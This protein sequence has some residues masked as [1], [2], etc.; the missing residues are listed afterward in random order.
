MNE[1]IERHHQDLRPEHSGQGKTRVPV[2]G[3]DALVKAVLL[4]CEARGDR[5]NATDL[6]QSEHAH[7]HFIVRHFENEEYVEPERFRR[8]GQV[9]VP[10]D[11][12]AKHL[13][14]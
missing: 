9:R 1:R 7:G 4:E 10:A 12:P 5:R 13:S 2:L 14:A 3:A 8:R 6:K 11:E